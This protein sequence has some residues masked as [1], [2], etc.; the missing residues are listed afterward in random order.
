M[1]SLHD[2]L[3]VLKEQLAEEIRKA[4]SAERNYEEQQ[5]RLEQQQRQIEYQNQKLEDL[6]GTLQLQELSIEEQQELRGQGAAAPGTAGAAGFE[7]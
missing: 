1:K 7:P 6:D 2:E 5:A 3:S 4:E